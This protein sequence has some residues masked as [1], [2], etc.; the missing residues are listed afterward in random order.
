MTPESWRAPPLRMT[1]MLEE[2]KAES[3]VAMAMAPPLMVTEPEVN[4]ELF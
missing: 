4:W 2:P 1:G 3:L